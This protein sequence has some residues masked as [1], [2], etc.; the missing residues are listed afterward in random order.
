[1]RVLQINSVCG[2]GSTGRIATDIHAI[3]KEQGH[4]SYIA[5]GRDNPINCETAIRIGNKIDNY[6]HVAKTR[7][8]DKHGFG[9][10]KA[11]KRFISKIKELNP[12]VIHLHNIHGY[13][14]NVEILFD[15]LK[16]ANKP[17]VWTLHDCWAFTGHCAY[18][19]YA[20]CDCWKID[21]DHKCIQ[22]RSYPASLFKNNSRK[23]YK[24][25]RN[26]FIGVK[27][28]TIV[29]PS[30]WLAQLVKQSFLGGYPI[31]VINNGIDLD[32]FKPTQSAF[33]ERQNL[34]N[35][36]IILG[37]A[38]VWDERKGKNYFKELSQRIRG[39]EIIILV[40][41][42]EK[43]LKV[44]PNNIIGVTQ[45]DSVR[46]LVDIYCSADV[47][48]NPTLEEVMGLT[49]VEALACGVPVITFNTGGSVECVDKKTGI[50][51]KKGNLEEIID[52]IKKVR[53]N[54]KSSYS[55]HCIDRTNKLYNKNHR[56]NEYT[57]IYSKVFQQ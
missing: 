4:E 55:A 15:Y 6:T 16:E 39:D 18:F 37:V 10:I 50:I 41:L 35:K 23:N 19:D 7:I 20:G 25:K 13:Y 53:E 22:K 9:S 21:G 36:F 34:N 38:N 32:L 12:D 49:N 14:I 26:S 28:L 1:M 33:R 2:I 8:F 43:Q 56:Y 45:T 44:L 17:V 47:F 29:T 27:N 3:L 31:K 5:Y 30:R 54:G 46:E 48:V 57:K 51:V 24:R 42:T 52:G 40:G 11:T